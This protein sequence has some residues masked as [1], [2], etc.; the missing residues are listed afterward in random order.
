MKRILFGILIGFMISA[1]SQKERNL[2]AAG[3]VLLGST[4]WLIKVDFDGCAS[5]V[6]EFCRRSTNTLEAFK[7]PSKANVWGQDNRFHATTIN[8]S[9]KGNFVFNAEIYNWPRLIDQIHAYHDHFTKSN[10]FIDFSNLD[11]KVL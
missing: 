4:D 2:I 6:Q 1:S 7:V 10:A 3:N 9:S 8:T 5:V 11:P